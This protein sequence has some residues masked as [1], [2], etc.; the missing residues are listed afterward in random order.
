MV[1]KIRI[2]KKINIPAEVFAKVKPKNRLDAF[3]EFII[4][5]LKKNR[6]IRIDVSKI[7]VGSELEDYLKKKCDGFLWLDVGPGT[8]ANLKGF[9][10]EVCSGWNLNNRKKSAEQRVKNMLTGGF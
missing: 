10:V 9:E 4:G 8:N 6:D 1:D 7:R 3:W 5:N 2:V